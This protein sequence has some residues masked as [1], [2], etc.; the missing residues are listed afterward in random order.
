MISL[1]NLRFA[2]LAATILLSSQITWAAANQYEQLLHEGAQHAAQKE[3]EK[4]V[5]SYSK[6]IESNPKNAAAYLKRA[7]QYCRMKKFDEAKA[8]YDKAISIEP[9]NAKTYRERGCMLG[10]LRR[11][12]EAIKDFSKSIE[13]NPKMSTPYI[14]RARAWQAL[15]EPEKARKD[16]D[17]ALKYYSGNENVG[18]KNKSVYFTYGTSANKNASQKKLAEIGKGLCVALRGNLAGESGDLDE[19]LQD[20]HDSNGMIQVRPDRRAVK[21][22]FK[23]K[24]KI[25]KLIN[26]YSQLIYLNPKDVD[27]FYNRGIIYVSLKQWDTATT[28]FARVVELSKWSGKAPLQASIWR[29]IGL[30]KQNKKRE[31]QKV[32]REAAAKCKDKNWPRPLLSYLEGTTSKEEIL[33]TA[34][35]LDQKTQAHCVIGFIESTPGKSAESI[36]HFEWIEKN[37]DTTLDEFVIALNELPS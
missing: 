9:K 4:A 17:T 3:P 22:S 30:C 32:L 36:K 31:A 34:Q 5:A 16:L 33:K 11:Y 21:R 19:A 29:G 10:S 18:I 15:G 28:N 26:S 25:E 37:G 23:E 1:S 14:D 12:H 7:F 24:G 8:D 2:L 27:S 20:I 35:G 13:I 6:A